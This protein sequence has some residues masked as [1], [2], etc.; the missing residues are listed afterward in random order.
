MFLMCTWKTHR[1]ILIYMQLPLWKNSRSD[2]KNAEDFSILSS[3]IFSRCFSTIQMPQRK[4]MYLH[5]YPFPGDRAGARPINFVPS[6][7]AVPSELC[8]SVPLPLNKKTPFFRTVCLRLHENCARDK[9]RSPGRW[10]KQSDMMYTFRMIYHREKS[11]FRCLA[12][13][14]HTQNAFREM[15][16]R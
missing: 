11:V 5:F 15:G 10:K 3:T 8:N 13:V 1:L 16:R 4:C 7:T 6:R 14:M 2:E 12:A 9:K